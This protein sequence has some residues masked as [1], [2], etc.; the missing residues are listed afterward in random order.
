MVTESVMRAEKRLLAGQ[1]IEKHKVRVISRIT[2]LQLQEQMIK[3]N[4]NKV[5]IMIRHKT[6]V[7]VKQPQKCRLQKLIYNV[8]LIL[9]NNEIFV[10][11]TIY[12]VY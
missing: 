2:V 1:S 8:F 9:I 12:C 3:T 4:Y 7:L 10:V 11:Y 6:L 5:Y